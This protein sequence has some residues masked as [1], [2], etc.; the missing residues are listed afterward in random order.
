M[1]TKIWTIQTLSKYCNEQDTEA[2][3]LKPDSTLFNIC[4]MLTYRAPSGNFNLFLN[5]LNRILKLLCKVELKSIIC[6]D[7]NYLTNNDEQK[8]L[9]LSY[10][11]PSIVNFPTSTQNQFSTTIDNIKH[12]FYSLEEYYQCQWL[13]FL[14]LSGNF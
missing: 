1:F 3:A 6:G 13:W 4:V 7:I 2:C 11:L 14:K 5:V 8:S 12:S 9:M 10:N